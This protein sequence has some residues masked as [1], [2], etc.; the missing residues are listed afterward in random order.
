MRRGI[1]LW[2]A[3][4]C[5]IALSPMLGA[6]DSTAG[7]IVGNSAPFLLKEISLISF[8]GGTYADILDLDDYFIDFEDD[9]LTYN[10]TS[11]INVDI[12]ISD[13]GILTLIA[14]PG[15]NTTGKMII[16]ASDGRYT[17]ESNVINLYV[18]DDLLH[19][20]YSNVS[21]NKNI[22]Y[23][24]DFVNFFSIWYDDRE[25]DRV[26]FEILQEGAGS[27]YSEWHNYTQN[28]SGRSNHSSFTEQIVVPPGSLITW[29]LCGY[30]RVGFENCTEEKQFSVYER[31]PIVP[32]G[33]PPG[34]SSSGGSSSGGGSG[35]GG[36]SGGEGSGTAGV[37][38]RIFEDVRG[39]LTES[40]N[41][42]SVDISSFSVSLKQG[43]SVSKVFQITN[44]GTNSLS[45]NLIISGLERILFLSDTNFTLASKEAKRIVM[46]VQADINL[47]PGEYYGEL[48]ISSA[49]EV[50]IPIAVFVNPVN[51]SYEIV[52]EVLEDFVKPG[53]N[54]SASIEITNYEDAVSHEAGIYYA[55]RDFNGN[56]YNSF[57]EVVV[58][59][60]EIVL[61]RSINV[62]KELMIGEYMFYARISS[63]KDYAI[64]ADS[65]TVGTK[66]KFDY[67]V[68]YSLVFISIFILSLIFLLMNI[69]YAEKKKK[70]KA[71]NL[72]VQF[73]QMKEFMKQGNYSAAA[74]LYINIK[75]TYGENVNED[76]L[77]NKEELA[78]KIKELANRMNLS[79]E[80]QEG[81]ETNAKKES[82]K[83]DAAKPEEKS[84]TAAEKK[85]GNVKEDENSH[86]QEKSVN[87]AD[88]D[89][90][91]KKSEKI[92]DKK[93]D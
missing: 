27:N 8:D 59:G 30:D 51:V 76:I 73:Q 86:E 32:G 69:R 53:K 4:F 49:Q 3:V 67:Y 44:Q 92:E 35:S 6:E 68:R 11:N 22:I 63:D 93:S 72:Y 78:E 39:S 83:K 1:L 85:E 12:I 79:D 10:A 2:L 56:T 24:N 43:F 48:I 7:I 23:Q 29:R 64:G 91:L 62:P 54:V 14:P 46:D 50:R 52:V 80:H 84:E 82:D 31:P 37:R 88:K 77:K 26:V 55:L 75:R 89:V 71:L 13:E 70:E 87:N 18:G 47:E 16:E 36:E 20:Y 57:E 9:P 90:E 28:I 5:L 45:F 60:K 15:M 19:P 21:I 38:K 65:F 61:E 58:M 40:A 17:T 33:S 74:N 41:N 34:G 81:G 25:L 42:F 66:Y